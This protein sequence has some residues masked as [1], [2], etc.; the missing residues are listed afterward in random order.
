M[1]AVIEGSVLR[2]GDVT[3]TSTRN[4]C[5]QRTER[6]D[7]TPESRPEPAIDRVRAGPD[8]NAVINASVVGYAIPAANPPSTRATNRTPID[9]ARAASRHAGTESAIP[10]TS[11]RLRP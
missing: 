5:E 6:R 2:E 4:I 3:E 8:H 11:I 10:P 9:G 7:R 1:D